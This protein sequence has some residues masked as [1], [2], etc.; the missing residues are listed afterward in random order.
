MRREFQT[1]GNGQPTG[2]ALREWSRWNGPALLAMIAGLSLAAGGHVPQ[3]RGE[4]PSF[5]MQEIDDGLNVGYAVRLIDMNQDGRRDIVVVD[6]NRLLW[7]ENPS[8]KRHVF[9]ED[10]TKTDDVCFAEYDIDGGGRLDFALG[11]DWHPG[12]TLS[13]GTLQWATRGKSPGDPW[14]VHPIAEEP[15]IHR[16]DWA[17]LD[18]DGRKELIVVPLFGKGATRRANFLDQPL[19]ITSYKI[20]A[21][22][23]NEP[24]KAEVINEEL[25]VSHN[26]LAA[27]VTGDGRLDLLTVSYEGVSLIRRNDQGKWSRELLHE[28]NQDTPDASRGASEIKLGRLANGE[29]YIATIEPWH[30]KQVVVYRQRTSGGATAAKWEREVLDDQLQWGHAVWCANLDGDGDD[31]LIIGVRDNRDE[32]ARCGVRIYDFRNGRWERTLLD[33]GGVAVEDLTAGD[34]DGDGRTDIVAVGR[35]TKNVRIYWNQGQRGGR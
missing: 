6:T 23:V 22:P 17:D 29:K 3:L 14:V 24:W 33:P 35:Q 21:D 2:G 7:Y 26:F 30:G 27:D 28:A 12:N 25:H 13:G 34:L 19:R 9:L 15:T 10:Q 11:A 20:P 18:G 16:I 31:E 32:S 5:R 4:E 1:P 8:W